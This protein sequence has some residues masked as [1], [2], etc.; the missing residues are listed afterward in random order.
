MVFRQDDGCGIQYSVL[1][2]RIRCKWDSSLDRADIFSVFASECCSASIGWRHCQLNRCWV[3]FLGKPATISPISV[4][5]VDADNIAAMLNTARLNGLHRHSATHQPGCH[6]RRRLR[7][8]VQRRGSR[9]I[10]MPTHHLP[11]WPLISGPAF[12]LFT[13]MD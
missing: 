9:E 10:G 5:N 4:G 8:R 7:R 1:V 6:S 3:L 2:F 13:F 11:S 12:S